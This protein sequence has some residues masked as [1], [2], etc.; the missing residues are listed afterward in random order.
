MWFSSS[1]SLQSIPSSDRSVIVGQDTIEACDSARNLGMQFDCEM[2]MQAQ[3]AKTT[4]IC[5][6]HLRRLRHVHRLLGRQVAAQLVSAFVISRLDY[7]NATLSVS[8]LPQSTLAPL[9]QVV[10]AA[11]R[12]VCD[13]RPREHVTSALIDLHWLPVAAR[14]KFKICM[15]AYQSLNSTAP[16][17]ISD[18]LQPVCSLQRQT[19]LCS[20][21]NSELFVPRTHVRL[22]ERAFSSAAPRLWNALLTDI[23]RAAALLTFKKKLK[24]FFFSKHL[25]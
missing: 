7:G 24:T 2:S 11:A 22:G 20:A 16:A 21:T 13:L 5:F 1:A 6:F 23:K 25:C 9:H 15:L 10:I 17:Y 18:M 14:I 8:G 3:I 12:L 19:N 4:Q